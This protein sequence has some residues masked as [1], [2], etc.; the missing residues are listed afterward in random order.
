[1]KYS[2]LSI[3]RKIGRINQL[4]CIAQLNNHD[5]VD[6]DAEQFVLLNK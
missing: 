5:S 2:V 4:H 3:I 1:M 6:D